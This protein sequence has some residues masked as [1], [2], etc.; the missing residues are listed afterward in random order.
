MA[1]QFMD[2]DCISRIQRGGKFVDQKWLHN[3]CLLRVPSVGEIKMGAFGAR[4]PLSAF[5]AY[6]LQRPVPLATNC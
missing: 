2:C 4:G 1:T 5:G 3:P 6:G